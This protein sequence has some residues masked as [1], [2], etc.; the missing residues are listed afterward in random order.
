MQGLLQRWREIAD[1]A[2]H[3]RSAERLVVVLGLAL[4]VLC[5]Y[6]LLSRTS[7]PEIV[8]IGGFANGQGQIVLTRLQANGID[9]S[10]DG[11]Q[12]VVPENQR[13]QAIVVLVEQDLYSE[14]ASEAFRDLVASTSPWDSKQN[15]ER[16]Y[17]IAKQRVL[18][19]IIRKMRH[20]RSAEVIIS[21]PDRSGFG[22]T[23]VRP[24]ASVTIVMEPQK[25]VNKA[26]VKAVA[27][28]VASS[29]A[30]EMTAKDVVVIDA[31]HA[32]QYTVEQD[33]DAFV[34]DQYELVRA[35]EQQYRR[36][37]LDVL[38]HIPGVAVAVNVKTDPVRT[39]TTSEWGYEENPPLEEEFSRQLRRQSTEHGGEPG[40]GPN[41]S[42]TI[43]GS[44]QPGMVETVDE[45]RKAYR[46]KPMVKE[47]HRTLAGHRVEHVGVSIGVP[48]G[49][50]L[51]LW[52]AM[53]PDT[54]AV[55]TTVQLDQ[56]A[57]NEMQRLASMVQPLI[58][59]QT[60]GTVQAQMVFTPTFTQPNEAG[61][62][63]ASPMLVAWMG[64]DWMSTAAAVGLSLIALGLM[65]W[66]LRRASRADALPSV[67][68]LAGIP[69]VLSDDEEILGQ[70]AEEVDTMDG[71]E[72]DP[73]ELES[74]K[75]A[76]QIS[77]LVSANP[78]E[79]GHLLSKWLREDDY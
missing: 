38:A 24:T 77:E 59:S 5:G 32:R 64:E 9:A 35:L 29:A 40:I 2:R 14:N 37:V 52:Q 31:N 22:A 78:G 73:D 25:H 46:A 56:F 67:E 8:S 71:V 51:Q 76:E 70:A 26:M 49:H 55:P 7:Q 50:V 13:E 58:L 21:Q 17:L 66:M 18:S 23:Q 30:A 47:A 11:Q 4:L 60:P 79:A 75:V 62:A 43:A 12:V 44:S 42:M 1:R 20:V 19:S 45:Q 69:P 65:V 54:N 36:K 6:L 16:A 41:T 74:R 39:E 48:R 27:G 34:D 63:G 3:L 57:Q 68:D 15:S 72:I 61:M 53:Q 33:A 28:L 10:L